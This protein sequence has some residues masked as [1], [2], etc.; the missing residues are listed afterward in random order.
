MK[1]LLLILI[2]IYQLTLSY[3]HGL[4]GKVF[5]NTRYCRFTPSCSQYTY[6][7][8]DKYGIFKGAKLSIN[9]LA[10]C[11]HTTPTGTYDPIK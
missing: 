9:R 6:E 2:K 10:R 7:A 1:Y 3:D 8:V 11:N 4:L 5:P